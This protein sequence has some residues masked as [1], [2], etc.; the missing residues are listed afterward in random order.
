MK[1]MSKNQDY[2]IKPRV[3]ISGKKTLEMMLQQQEKVKREEILNTL[4]ILLVCAGLLSS[5]IFLII[6]VLS[7]L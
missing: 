1:I 4:K 5:F 2:F 3:F 7:K 6:F